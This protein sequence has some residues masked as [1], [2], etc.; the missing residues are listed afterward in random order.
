MLRSFYLPSVNFANSV[1]RHLNCTISLQLKFCGAGSPA[2][3][4]L[5]FKSEDCTI[6]MYF[7][8]LTENFGDIAGAAVLVW[9]CIPTLI[10]ASKPVR[11]EN[12]GRLKQYCILLTHRCL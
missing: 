9:L 5:Q 4:P 6:F 3:L 10:L 1:D 7:S 8:Q 12:R 2:R 11:L